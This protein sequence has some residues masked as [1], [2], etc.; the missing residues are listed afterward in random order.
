MGRSF[1]QKRLVGY[2]LPGGKLFLNTLDSLDNN[3]YAERAFN[4]LCMKSEGVPGNGLASAPNRSSGFFLDSSCYLLDKHSPA[5][6]YLPSRYTPA[7]V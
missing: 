2:G 6:D 5:C 3:C 1:L 4:S 7:A